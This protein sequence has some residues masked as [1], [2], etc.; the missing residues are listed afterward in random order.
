M[1]LVNHVSGSVFD[2]TNLAAYYKLE[3]TTDS[4]PS[5]LTL[6]NSG[7]TT[8][9]AGK[10][11]NCANLVRAS[12]Q[13]LQVAN[14]FG[15]D[16]G[17][18]TI[19]LWYNPLILP[20][21]NLYHALC[22]QYS[23]GTDSEY[24]IYYRNDGGV[25]KVWIARTRVGVVSSGPDLAYTMNVGTWYHLAITY[26]TSNVQGYINGVPFGPATAASG[27]GS[28]AVTDKFN[29][30]YNYPSYENYPDGK[31]DEVLIFS[32]AW[33]AQEVYNYYMQYKSALGMGSNY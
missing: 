8:F 10:Y 16:G 2:E 9:V 15:I 7:T 32:R 4:G 31:I 24:S 33:T 29:I 27:N 6:T 14:N 20:G 3:N 30:G 13:Y 19:S 17:A 25:Y 18:I 5:G 12:S 28:T 21:N 22:T 23:A 26:D 11:G 1:A